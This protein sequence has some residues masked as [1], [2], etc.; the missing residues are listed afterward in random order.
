MTISHIL[1]VL[2]VRSNISG[3]TLMSIWL[4]P[5]LLFFTEMEPFL[6]NE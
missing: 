1:S 3:N 5:G 6:V 4:A 2:N